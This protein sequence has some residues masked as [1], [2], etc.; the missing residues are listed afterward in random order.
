M[1]NNAQLGTANLRNASLKSAELMGAKLLATR[2]HGASLKDALLYGADLTLTQAQ[3]AD[4]SQARLEGASLRGTQLQGAS[5]NGSSLQFARFVIAN[6]Q[7]A[8]LGAADLSAA[9]LNSVGLQGADLSE[10]AMQYATLSGIH[11]WRAKNPSCTNVSIDRQIPDARL[12][13]IPDA[14]YSPDWTPPNIPDKE[15]PATSDH[16][17]KF[18]ENSVAGISIEERR[19]AAIDRMR[20]GLVANPAQDD[21][22]AIEDV[23]RKCGEISQQSQTEFENGSVAFLRTLFCDTKKRAC[24]R[25]RICDVK[26]SVNAVAEAMIRSGPSAQLAQGM[27]GTDAGPCSATVELDEQ[28]KKRLREAAGDTQ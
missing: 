10:S 4:L 9:D 22:A 13:F 15:V 20:S 12:P 14:G 17:A 3:G 6:L 26:R 18:I 8:D 23:W 11:V 16:I 2:L 1:L 25:R 27:L 5:L 21:T 24:A 19:Q 28:N 7:G